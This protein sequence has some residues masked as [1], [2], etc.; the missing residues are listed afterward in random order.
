VHRPDLRQQVVQAI[1]CWIIYHQ[2]GAESLRKQPKHVL[3]KG[4]VWP[5][6]PPRPRAT[7]K[8]LEI[9]HALAVRPA[10]HSLSS[11]RF[12]RIFFRRIR[13]FI[14]GDGAAN[15]RWSAEFRRG[16]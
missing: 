15:L 5:A 8:L 11:H 10:M 14:H 9:T 13:Q 16:F 4:S 7:R 1:R 12:L 2:D 3:W 6:L